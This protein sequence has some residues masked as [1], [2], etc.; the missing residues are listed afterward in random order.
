[1]TDEQKSGKGG[2]TRSRKEAEAARRAQMKRPKT[3]REQMQQ[4]RKLRAAQQDRQQAAMR[5]TGSEADLPLRDRGPVRALVRDYVDR[6][7]TIAEFMLPLLLVILVLSFFKDPTI[8]SIVFTTWI[9]LIFAI[10][11]DEF[12][13]VFFLKRELKKRFKSNETRGAAFYAILRSTQIRRLRLPVPAINLGE[14]L[15]DRY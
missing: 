11:I 3:R 8:T 15:R 4:Q 13:L 7:R 6:R 12:F 9:A 2:P 5:G 10:A 14:N 1:M